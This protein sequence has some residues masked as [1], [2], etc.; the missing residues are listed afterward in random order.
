MRPITTPIRPSIMKSHFQP[1]MPAAPSKVWEM[2][3]E[4]RPENAPETMLDRM[5]FH[6]LQ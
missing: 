6:M 3:P 1:R 5:L 4:I 2:E